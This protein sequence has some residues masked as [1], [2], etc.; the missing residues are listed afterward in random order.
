MKVLIHAWHGATVG[1]TVLPELLA[2]WLKTHYKIDA[3]YNRPERDP[4]GLK[5]FDALILGP[6]GV[7]YDPGDP[8]KDDKFKDYTDY[9]TGWIFQAHNL[10]I[11]IMGFNLGVQQIIRP[12]K[13]K[14]WAR[15]LNLCDVITTR[16]DHTA[17]IFRNIGVN[18]RIEP[19]RDL[20]YALT[21]FR[22]K[23]KPGP[24][25]PVLGIN[26][27]STTRHARP[28]DLMAWRK[29]IGLLRK[30]FNMKF[31]VF[32][33]AE[34]HTA[35][36]FHLPHDGWPSYNLKTVPD[37]YDR[38]D[39]CITSHFHSHVFSAMAGI[40]FLQVYSASAGAPSFLNPG[41][42]PK[43][44]YKNIW[45]MDE[46]KYKH[47]WNNRCKSL[48]LLQRVTGLVEND[49][50]IRRHLDHIRRTMKPLALKNF[51]VLR[52]WLEEE[53]KAPGT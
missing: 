26:L 4:R 44:S 23:S 43:G 6:C 32:G 12:E 15:A 35:R 2:R 42:L 49:R 31:L 34:V 51:E 27:F 18:T 13:A 50:I 21:C 10:G 41:D 36:V 33:P 17:Q 11:P 28:W 45:A 24:G 46:F 38:L 40:P 9:M 52:E 53:V 14:Q 3:R 7:V 16:E 48:C 5:S 25:R 20:G 47:L 1:D 30:S 29:A 19:C 22:L 39:F 8:T 37:A